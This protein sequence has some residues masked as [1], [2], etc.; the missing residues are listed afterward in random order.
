METNKGHKIIFTLMLHLDNNWIDYWWKK[1][2][3]VGVFY[4]TG[5][6]GAGVGSIIQKKKYN[7]FK[8]TSGIWCWKWCG[9][10]APCKCA[11]LS[12]GSERPVMP[13]W[14]PENSGNTVQV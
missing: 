11:P 8:L 14:R 9:G 6:I 1:N 2:R 5:L 3:V 4:V 7:R 10:T 12:I 13:E